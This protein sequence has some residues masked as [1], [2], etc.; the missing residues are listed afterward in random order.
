MDTN[1]YRRLPNTL[2][3]PQYALIW[4]FME[5]RF[6]KL[7]IVWLEKKCEVSEREKLFDKF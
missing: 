5:V 3:R 7:Y 1:L 2:H 6:M 4:D